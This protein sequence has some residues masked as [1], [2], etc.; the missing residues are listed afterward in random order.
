MRSFLAAIALVAAATTTVSA[1]MV[2]IV[3]SPDGKS[4]MV[5]F[6]DD[7][8]PD[9][10]VRM[11]KVT[12]LKLYA[13]SA[14]GKPTAIDCQKADH[15][16]T[17]DL[18]AGTRQVFGEAIYGLSSRSAK[19]TLLVFHPKAVLG[20][21]MGPQATRDD[22]ATLAILPITTEG[23]TRFRL[24]AKGQPVADSEG[25]ILLPDGTKARLKTD[26]DGYTSAFTGSGRCAVWLRHV[27]QQ[28]GEH[29]GQ[30][31]EEIRHYATLVVDLP[32]K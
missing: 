1:H 32:Q 7:L 3:P 14:D 29:A 6:S 27:K 20:R 9:T 12:G 26:Q 2:Y 31:Y 18:A 15:Q 13:G 4:V 23:K 19:P 25:S 8:A 30:K 21:V 10:K 28:S 11:T 5:V 22:T 17:A 16:F 24:L